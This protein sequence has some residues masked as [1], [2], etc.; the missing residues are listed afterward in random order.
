MGFVFSRRRCFWLLGIIVIAL[1][2]CVLRVASDR[3]HTRVIPWGVGRIQG[4]RSNLQIIREFVAQFKAER[5]VY[6][7]S[8]ESMEPFSE[9]GGSD[10]SLAEYLSD[11]N[12]NASTHAVLDGNGGWYYEPMSGRVKVNLLKRVDAYLQA[13]QGKDEGQIP[14]DW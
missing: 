13:Y 12:G 7:A 14:S 5:G 4:T 1:L 2:A 8:L 10:S 3:R 6:P 9:S 11:P